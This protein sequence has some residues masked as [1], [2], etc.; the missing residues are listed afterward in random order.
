MKIQIRENGDE[1]MKRLAIVG[2]A[3]LV[4]LIGLAPDACASMTGVAGGTG[5]PAATLGPYRMAP[6][7]PDARPEGGLV[8]YVTSPLGGQVGFSPALQHC[9]VPSSWST[10][11][12]DYTGDVYFSG[13]DQSSITLTMPSQTKAFYLY[14]EP[15]PFEPWRI[16]AT[17]ADGCTTTIAVSQVVDGDSGAA[18]Y[19]FWCDDVI[20]SITIDYMGC[21]GF[22]VGEFGIACVPAPG[23]I[24]LGGIG[25]GVLSRLRKRRL[26]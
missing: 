5:A 16:T 9:I 10:W 19:G 22:A 2:V 26:L 1:S 24:V 11:S 14:A 8:T 13:Y 18:Y 3:V 7:G 6:F 21:N 12:H 4:T 25:L 17:G 23:A 15:N 20:S